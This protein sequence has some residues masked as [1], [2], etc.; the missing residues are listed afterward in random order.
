MKDI[1]TEVPLLH[2]SQKYAGIAAEKEYIFRAKGTRIGCNHLT[3]IRTQIDTICARIKEKTAG[4]V[5]L[6]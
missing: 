3:L 6:A 5:T 2:R 4:S 1:E